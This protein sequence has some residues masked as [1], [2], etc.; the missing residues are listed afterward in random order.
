M[1][2]TLCG[3]DGHAKPQGP[4]RG[5]P[6]GLLAAATGKRQF[7][8]HPPRANS[9]SPPHRLG[10][11]T[12]PLRCPWPDIN[13]SGPAFVA[14]GIEHRSPKAGVAG[15]N[16]AGGTTHRSS[17]LG[18][19]SQ[20]GNPARPRTPRPRPFAWTDGTLISQISPNGSTPSSTGPSDFSVDSP[21]RTSGA[22]SGALEAVRC[23]Q[24]RARASK[25]C[26]S[27]SGS[28]FPTCLTT[29]SPACTAA[30]L[31][32]AGAIILRRASSVRQLSRTVIP[33]CLPPGMG[34]PLRLRPLPHHVSYEHG[35]M[36]NWTELAG[37]T[38]SA[39]L[40]T[41]AGGVISVRVARWQTSRAIAAQTELATAQQAAGITLARQQWERQRSAEAAQRLLERVAD[42]YAWLPSLPDLSMDTPLLS[43]SAREQCAGALA[44]LRH[45]M[46]TDLFS[47]QDAA[48]RD[49]Y[50]TL[51]RLA[52]DVGWRGVGGGNRDRQ[53]RDVRGYLRYVQLTLEAVVDD[54]VPPTHTAPPCLDR[55]GDEGWVPPQVP[56]HWHDPADG[57]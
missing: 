37:Q 9:S 24:K 36:S 41:L 18:I 54:A 43:V 21:L 33:G 38:A 27:I 6:T 29:A 13:L 55:Q 50:R 30:W 25:I 17:D 40:G 31:S 5:P 1:A 11:G 3:R 57:S 45:G 32:A 14:Q 2:E 46:Q 10:T 7:R 42:L 49:R 16:P 48:V 53:I 34:H 23:S 44:S 19:L 56:W 15:S 4:Q 28:S 51:V 26:R 35:G 39:L 22:G 12:Y 20:G 8:R 52:F 47:I